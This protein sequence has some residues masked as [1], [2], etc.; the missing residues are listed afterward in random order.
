MRNTIAVVSLRRIRN[1]AELIVRRAHSPLIAVVKDD[2]YGH[3]AEAVAQALYGTASAF[4][5]S[6]VDEGAALRVAGIDKEILVLS[7]PV[8]R[9]EAERIARYRLTATVSSFVSLRLLS[10]TGGIRAHLAVNTGMNRY[11]FRP[12]HVRRACEAALGK[13]E[14][15]GVYSHFYRPEDK[16]ARERQSALFR[17][18]AETV[19]N[20]FPKAIRHLAATGGMLAGREY[21]FDAVR[22]GIGLYGYLPTGFEGALPVKPAMKVYAPVSA[23]GTFIG[24]GVGYQ[25][26]EKTYGK[27]HTLR[28]GYGDGFF[29]EGGLGTGKLC[30]DACIREGKANVGSWRLVL[31]DASAYAA[32]HGTTAYEALTSV[33]ERAVK[34]YV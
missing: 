32:A 4:A 34:F 21:A 29:R 28:F 30:M 1:N 24:G 2:G 13:I 10:A 9:S 3:G 27:L 19:R 6:S 11:G 12:E 20:C 31:K 23:C 26:A 18:A 16:N 15:T 8:N 7:P 22:C 17:R 33:G 5:V 25:T 14:V